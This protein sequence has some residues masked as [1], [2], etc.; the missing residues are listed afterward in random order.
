MVVNEKALLRCMKE[1]YKNQGYTVAQD[2]HVVWINGGYWLVYA[3]R[4]EISN[5]VLGL[6]ATHTRKTPVDG[7][8]YKVIKGDNGPIAQRILLDAAMAPVKTMGEL[9]EDRTEQDITK[10]VKINIR[11]DNYGVWQ[12]DTFLSVMLI[13]P[14][15]EA[16][17]DDKKNVERLGSGLYSVDA[18]SGVWVLPVEKKDAADQLKHL[19]GIRWVLS[20][21]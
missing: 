13:D 14:R 2:D 7:D 11:Y 19:A 8:A 10:M 9:L 1:A 20:R 16:L 15:Y 4:D 3:D 17:I 18:E 21:R 5:E 6:I 12:H